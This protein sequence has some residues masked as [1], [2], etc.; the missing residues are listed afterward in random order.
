MSAREQTGYPSTAD[1]NLKRQKY[2]G[3]KG[4]VLFLIL[5]SAFVPLSTDI[6]LPALPTMMK[7]FAVSQYKLNMTLVVFFISYGL[8]TLVWGP[9]SDKY[10][11][12]PVLFVGITMYVVAGGLCALSASIYMLVLFRILQAVGAG[13]ACAVATAVVKDSYRG[14]RQET[15][16]A[17]TSSMPLISPA[18][19]P[20]VGAWLLRFTSWRG[21]FVVQALLGLVI[22]GFV[23]AYQETLLSRGQGSIRQTFARLGVVLAHRRF[24]YLLLI[25]NVTSVA[26]MAFIS[27]SSYIYQN[28]FG[29][30]SQTYSFYFAFNSLF[31]IAGPYLYLWSARAFDRVTILRA[32]FALILVSGV[33]VIAFGRLQPWLFALTMVPSAAMS[34]LMRPP[35]T[36]LLLRQHA[37]DAGST[38]AVMMAFQ[39]MMGTLGIL[40]VSPG[41]N[42]VLLVGVLNVIL[43][44]FAGTAWLVVSRKRVV[45]VGSD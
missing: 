34:S 33:L 29:V 1:P 20:L 25:F 27:S 41:V 3:E 30:S 24:L 36:F 43:G 14:K 21:V 17:I 28:F 15:V 31:M 8:A 19:G 7:V 45:W 23:F 18:I 44:L 4:L 5:L 6:Y 37:G 26:S 42:M 38:S 40:L 2:L 16:L 22:L 11:R 10:G 39:T 12:R 13:A 35:A 32:A 9:L